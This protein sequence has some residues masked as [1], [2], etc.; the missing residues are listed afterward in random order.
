[1][2]CWPGGQAEYVLI[3]YA[4]FNLLKLPKDKALEREYL[5]DLCL[6]SDILPTGYDAA[7]K[8]KV[9]AGST[10]YIAGNVAFVLSPLIV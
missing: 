7:L 2:G 4:D 3:P 9:H 10:V 5:L 1:M 6:L 8:A